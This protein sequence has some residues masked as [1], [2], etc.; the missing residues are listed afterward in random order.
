MVDDGSRDGTAAAVEA[1]GDPRVRLI[2]QR[3]QG[4]SFAINRGVAVSTGDFIKI[5]DADDWLNPDHCAAQVAALADRMD[6]VAD[7]R[8]GYFITDA[9]SPAI[10]Q[11][12]VNRHYDDP[13][14]WLVDSLTCDDGMMGGWRWLIPREIWGRT[15][16]WDE[17]L[18]LNNDFDFSVR[19]LLHSA[20]VRYAHPAVYSYRKGVAGALSGSSG[21]AA[22]TSAM[23]TTQSGC[24]HLLA[25]EDSPRIRRLCADR[26]Q[27][28]LFRFYPSFPDLARRAQQEVKRLGGSSVKLEGGLLLKVLR[29]V[30]GW[31]AVRRIQEWAYHSPWRSVVRWKDQRRLSR[32]QPPGG[33]GKTHE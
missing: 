2:R 13:L 16:G 30:L 25:R 7:C 9:R 31:R 19:L 21:V 26:W 3:N 24:A 5:L 32:V 28:W 14:E 33:G 29:P 27:R 12:S 20:G 18:S 22:M 8:W 6:C 1:C 15:G 10:K 4:Q 23:L 17:R 11:E